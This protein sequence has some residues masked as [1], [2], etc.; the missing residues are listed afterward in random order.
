MLIAVW[1]VTGLVA[2][3]NLASGGMK[4]FRPITALHP[5]M[6]FTKDVPPALTRFIGVVEILGAIGIVLPV[7]TGIAPIL[8]PIAALGLAL[9]QLIAFVFHLVRKEISPT[10]LANVLLFAFAVFVAV[11]RFAGV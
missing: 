4:V 3:A 6:P 9:I 10:L 11:E 5:V 2:L 7:L 1:I 8:T